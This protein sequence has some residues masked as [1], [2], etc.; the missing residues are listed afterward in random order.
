[1]SRCCRRLSASFPRGSNT[2]IANWHYRKAEALDGLRQELLYELPNPPTD[3]SIKDV[4][5]RKREMSAAMTTE[6]ERLFGSDTDLV[7]D[8]P[9]LPKHEPPPPEGRPSS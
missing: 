4:S 2:R 9:R 8:P 5:L 6:W 7:K 3:E 1:L